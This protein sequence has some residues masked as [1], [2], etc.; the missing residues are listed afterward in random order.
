[1]QRRL[2]RL[3]AGRRRVAAGAEHTEAGVE[4]LGDDGGGKRAEPAGGELERQ[5]QPVQLDADP[6][7]VGCVPVVQDE[8]GRGGGR[9]VD[10]QPHGL[11]ADEVVRSERLLKVRNREGRHPENDL[12]G[13]AE[14]LPTRRDRGQAGGGPQQPVDERGARPEDVLAV[15]HDEE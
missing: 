15:V 11:E 1:M 8:V 4:P 6:G 5:R 12:P 14:R 2:Q 13:D 9:T 3:L 7:D 10:E